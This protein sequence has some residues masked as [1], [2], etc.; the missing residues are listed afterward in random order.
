VAFANPAGS[1]KPGLFGA[2]EI[3]LPTRSGV[4]V[5]AEAVIDTGDRRYLFVETTAGHF[6]PRV[7]TVGERSGDRLE[8][9]EGVADGERVASSGNF[10]IDSE[11]RLKASNA[12]SPATG[13]KP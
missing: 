13:A 10:F 11:S 9:L 7:V 8:I 3:G 12:E 6:E 4:M 5:P 2:V 1:L